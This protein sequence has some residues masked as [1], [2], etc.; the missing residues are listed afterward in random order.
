MIEQF[1]VISILI[2]LPLFG[3]LLLALMRNGNFIY[4]IAAGTS[5]L[6]FLISLVV[7]LSFDKNIGTFQ[8]VEVYSW[9]P[10]WSINLSFGIDGISIAFVLLIALMTFLIILL[11]KNQINIKRSAYY[12]NILVLEAIML[13]LFTSTNLI[14]F[15][16]FW[17]AS[18]IPLFLLIGIWGGENRRHAAYKFLLFT[19]GGSIFM[20]VAIIYLYF[21]GDGSFEFVILSSLNL[22]LDRESLLFWAF[23]IAFGVKIPLFPLHTWLPD[24]YYEA[25]TPVTIIL[26][27]ILAKMGSYGLVRITLPVFPQA[28]YIYADIL[29]SICLI[30]IIYGAY[31]AISQRDLK[32]FIAYSSMSHMGFIVLGIFSLNTAGIEG[33]MMQMINHAV[34]TGGLFMCIGVLQE[35]GLTLRMDDYGNL[36]VKIPLFVILLSGLILAGSGFPGLNYFVGEFLVLSGTFNTSLTYGAVAIIGVLLGV[37]YMCWLYYRVILK[38]HDVSITTLKDLTWREMLI[39]TPLIIAVFYLGIQ[40]QALL[41]YFHSPVMYIINRLSG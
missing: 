18:L 24:S 6:T 13:G 2:L 28:S 20:F 14:Q 29:V 27:S 12:I 16:I 34:I 38:K 8:M 23:I 5:F 22:T 3:A 37:F 21:L 15:F 30:T 41:S 9:Y 32:R 40:P 11:S 10:Q 4:E 35:R 33:S 17:E 39:F 26:S 25:P 1:Q 36:T 19:F 31:A 7:P